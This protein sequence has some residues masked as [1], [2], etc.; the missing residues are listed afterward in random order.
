MRLLVKNT[1]EGVITMLT[2]LL[3]SMGLYTTLSIGG[4]IGDHILPRSK[5]LNRF[6]DSLPMLW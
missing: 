6:I 2:F 5:A 1:K 3:I 4:L